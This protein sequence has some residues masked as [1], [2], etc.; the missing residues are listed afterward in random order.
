MGG[1]EPA[2]GGEEPSPIGPV[3]A[4]AAARRDGK[5]ERLPFNGYLYRLLLQQ[6]PAAP[7]GAESFLKDGRLV[8]GWAV[9]ASPA[10]YGR[11]GVMTFIASDAG[12]IYQRDLGE[13]TEE[14][15]KAMESFDPGAGWTRVP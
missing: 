5:G 2:A 13:G 3:L 6:G 1:H 14:A 9:V 7:G 11:T 4:E 8:A 12:V 10:D 15:A